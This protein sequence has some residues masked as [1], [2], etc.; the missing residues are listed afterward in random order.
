MIKGTQAAR[1]VDYGIPKT[2]LWRS[3]CSKCECLPPQRCFPNGEQACPSGRCW[4]WRKAN[5]AFPVLVFPCLLATHSHL[6]DGVPVFWTNCSHP[7]YNGTV[8]TVVL[9]WAGKGQQWAGMRARKG[10]QWA[11][12]RA[13]GRTGTR[14]DLEVP[15]SLKQAITA[16]VQHAVMC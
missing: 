4:L 12:M 8:Q 13:G 9:V 10:Q 11:G 16:S 15:V 3:R 1:L 5:Q 7:V 2:S 14:K 6:P